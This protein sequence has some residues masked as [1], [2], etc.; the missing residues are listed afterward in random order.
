MQEIS[1]CVR[2][3]PVDELPALGGSGWVKYKKMTQVLKP[4]P[5]MTIVFLD[6]T[7]LNIGSANNRDVYWMMEHSTRKP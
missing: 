1:A 4:G 7:A 5:A 3:N 2:D 6:V